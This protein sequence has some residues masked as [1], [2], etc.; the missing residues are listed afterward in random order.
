MWP[1]K[2]FASTSSN[3]RGFYLTGYFNANQF[4]ESSPP[5]T[6]ENFDHDEISVYISSFEVDSPTVSAIVVPYYQLLP[7]EEIHISL[8]IE[9]NS[10]LNRLESPCRDEYPKH[11]KS[12]VPKT[13]D[14]FYSPIFY[15]NLPYN[16]ITCTRICEANLELPICDCYTNADTWQYAGKDD[17]DYPLCPHFGESCHRTA[18]GDRARKF[19]RSPDI[20][21]CECYQKCNWYRFRV[22][23]ADKMR[24]SYGENAFF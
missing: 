22:V 2:A 11:L 20:T 1:L 21:P 24:H 15:P 16:H 6:Y 7:C 17:A 13:A 10:L 14:L 18:D 8:A 23:T 12:L 5:A 19:L 9:H 3:L 4:I